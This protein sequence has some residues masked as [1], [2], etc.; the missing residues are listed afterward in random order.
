MAT[1]VCLS[2][3]S[4]SADRVYHYG[5]SPT[6][7]PPDATVVGLAVNNTFFFKPINAG[8]GIQVDET[9]NPGAITI[10]YTG[11][12]G[13]PYTY[14]TLP[15]PNT[16][17]TVVATMS[18]NDFRFRGFE[19]GSN[20]GLDDTTNP[21]VV[22]IDG[23][24][25]VSSVQP[26]ST[27][28]V[29]AQ[30]GRQFRVKPLVPGNNVTIANLGNGVS[31]SSA[32]YTYSS[33]PIPGSV[34]ITDTQ[35]GTNLGFKPL[36]AGTGIILDSVTV[37]GAII[38]SA[39]QDTY[40]TLPVP[41]AQ[42]TVVATKVGN[43]FQFKGFRGGTNITVDDVTFAGVITITGPTYSTPNVPGAF[44]VT[45]TQVG[46]DFRFKPING[47]TN[48]VIDTSTLLGALTING[49]TFASSAGPG[50]S[51]VDP[52]VGTQFR[53]KR[54]SPGVNIILDN[55]SNPSTIAING[56]TYSS[57][58]S[59]GAFPITDTQVANDFR[60]KPLRNGTNIVIDAASIVGTLILNGPTLASTGVGTVSLVNPQVGNE[61]RI[62]TLSAGANIIL[63]TS[64]PGN[65][66]ISGPSPSVYTYSTDVVPGS[67]AT[68]VGVQVG[69]NFGFKPLNNGTN[70]IIEETTLPGALTF[71]GPTYSTP[72]IPG[73]FPITGTQVGNDFRFKPLNAGTNMV[74]DTIT[75]PGSITINGPTLASSAVVGGTPIIDAQVG[76]QFRAR[77]LLPGINT[78]LDSITTP[79]GVI[80]NG[81]TLASSA[82]VGG[83]PIID[84]QVGNQFRAKQLLAGTNMT[85]DSVTTPGGIIVNGPSLTATSSAGQSLVDAQVGNTFKIKRVVPGS[86]ITLD[87]STIPGSVIVN[88]APQNVYTYSTN[89]VVGFDAT[90]VGTQVGNDFRFKPLKSGTGIAIDETSLPGAITITS[91]AQNVRINES[92]FVD[93]VFGSDVTGVRLEFGLPFQTITAA[94]AVALPG[95][96]I[97][98][99]P[100]DYVETI[101]LLDRV[102][103]VFNS[104]ANLVTPAIDA[105]IATGI[106]T[107]NVYSMGNI[108]GRINV[109]G[110]AGE[111]YIQAFELIS[112]GLAAIS[113]SGS[114]TNLDVLAGSIVTNT[115]NILNISSSPT[116]VTRI[117]SNAISSTG[118]SMLDLIDFGQVQIETVELQATTT[119][120]SV[121][122]ASISLGTT[123][124]TK[125]LLNT[126]NSVL[127]T[128]SGTIFSISDLNTASVMSPLSVVINSKWMATLGFVLNISSAKSNILSPTNVYPNLVLNVEQLQ[129]VHTAG[130]TN[131]G[132]YTVARSNFTMNVALMQYDITTTTLSNLFRLLTSMTTLN[133]DNIYPLSSTA[134]T[135][136][137]SITDGA[138]ASTTFNTN[139]A[140]LR[141]AINHG[142]SGFTGGFLEVNAKILLMTVTTVTQ[143]SDGRMSINADLLDISRGAT[144]NPIFTSAN[145]GTL[146]IKANTLITR[147]T[148]IFGNGTVFSN[149]NTAV[150]HL[151]IGTYN[152]IM[153]NPSM[154]FNVSSGTF[155]AKINTATEAVL[156]IDSGVANINIGNLTNATNTFSLAS[157]F[158]SGTGDGIISYNVGRINIST[159]LTMF[160]I[161][162]ATTFNAVIGSLIGSNAVAQRICNITSSAAS[163]I[164]INTLSSTN[165]SA[166]NP[167]FS[168][169]GTGQVTITGVDWA[170][171]TIN[172]SVFAVATGSNL[173]LNINNVSFSSTLSGTGQFLATAGT[174]T[175][176][177]SNLVST[178]NT[179]TSIFNQTNGTARL[180][181]GFLNSLATAYRTSTGSMFIDTVKSTNTNNLEVIR[182]A[183]ASTIEFSGSYATNG[184]NAVVIDNGSANV[185]LMGAKLYSTNAAIFKSTAGLMNVFSAGSIARVTVDVLRILIQGLLS[186][187]SLLPA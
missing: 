66:S 163:S 110:H 126:V 96:T 162:N 100:G 63:D 41:Q 57:N 81:P 19:A 38:I 161:T 170:N 37:P 50:I 95:D 60:F 59:A 53:T 180:N 152:Q 105:I 140:D 29:D 112:N 89:P 3:P 143:V 146:Y 99:R 70:I 6:I 159:A 5:T 76:N 46:S 33:N 176:T 149:T 78:T 55:V 177:I 97:V 10:S 79:G 160:N 20:I 165:I 71:N 144:G 74:L 120:T 11:A 80:I 83:T 102:N 147:A 8:T 166:T 150:T 16:N 27:S 87:S 137:V 32:S 139:Y 173:A 175:A 42:V 172:Q 136:T 185:S 107:A 124:T 123:A 94:L 26:G 35:V 52:Q 153:S 67:D 130:G 174:V 101:T 178:S 14:S 128:G 58:I 9:T 186:I 151:D 141:G 106:V 169:A 114:T 44:P 164:S 15:D 131:I 73:T 108:T 40:S 77:Q 93:A 17:V 22:R 51:L 125:L 171:T 25:L 28:L 115:A 184:N 62:K 179:A 23:P 68:I 65:V 119:T 49:P 134:Q 75:V 72:N 167:S 145:T 4:I 181:V 103:I 154:S 69:N 64:V 168:I 56:P 88:G 158:A 117:V 45:D 92:I 30:V 61:F 84:A 133:I 36:V 54:I 122:S 21:N 7:T 18:G 13:L 116:S 24:T 118:S 85:L 48:V 98:V 182:I 12:P 111:L 34:P 135:L 31:I 138:A 39:I 2:E 148:A 157:T 156:Q 1:S 187:S 142:G 129:N 104:G 113:M 183:G 86:N 47:G 90:V 155:I 82:V 109:I 132:L 43:D 127:Q 121:V 91:L